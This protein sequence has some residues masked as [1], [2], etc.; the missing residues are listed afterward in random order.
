[1]AVIR[2]LLALGMMLLIGVMTVSSA[3][4]VP[5]CLHGA[6]QSVCASDCGCDCED[7]DL[8]LPTCCLDVGQPPDMLLPHAEGAPK[9]F[10]KC[11]V[12]VALCGKR[13]TCARVRAEPEV[14]RRA[15]GPPL[16]QLYRVILC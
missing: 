4:P 3:V 6:L 12:D 11:V 10:T 1:M 13:F 14:L 2:K 15:E 7:Q 16:Y 9:H 8:P 5:R